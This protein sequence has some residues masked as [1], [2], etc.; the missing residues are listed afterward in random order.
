[1][2]MFCKFA[3]GCL[4]V[5]FPEL[6][7]RMLRPLTTP[8]TSLTFWRGRQS[9]LRL[10]KRTL[11]RYRRFFFFCIFWFWDYLPLCLRNSVPRTMTILWTV[12]RS[13]LSAAR[14]ANRVGGSSRPGSHCKWRGDILTRYWERKKTWATI[15][16][17]YVFPRARYT[18]FY[19]VGEINA[20]IKV[21]ASKAGEIR[22]LILQRL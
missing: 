17:H 20:K 18:V 2:P 14:R 8:R 19:H 1:M 15:N 9:S 21:I 5:T 11:S 3:T 4:F 6:A 16:N 22:L 13:R 12:G 10:W 7:M